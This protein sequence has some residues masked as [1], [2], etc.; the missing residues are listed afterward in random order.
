MGRRPHYLADAG[1][2]RTPQLVVSFDTETSS[3]RRGQDEVLRLRCWD[4]IV[5]D[6]AGGAGFRQQTVH[7][8]GESA[9]GL[10]NVLQAAADIEGE[11][12]AFAHNL[13]FDLA[14]TSL[15]MVL[16][17][18][19]WDTD[20]VNLG[21]ESC[22]FVM[23]RDRQKLVITDSWSWLRASLATAAK[24]VGM[25]SGRL[26]GE[27]AGLAAW[28]RRCRHDVEIL[29]RLLAELLD[30]WDQHGLGA[31]GVTGSACGW[32]ALRAMIPPRSVLVG[33]DPPRTG[34]ER[35]ALYSGRKEVWRVGEL[36]HCWVADYDLA[37]AH[38]TIAAHL[39]LPTVPLRPERMAAIADPLRPPEHIGT[40]CEV[41]ISTSQPVAPVLI[42][43]DV[44]WPV[45][46]FR[47]VLTSV[48]L[49]AVLPLAERVECLQASWYRLGDALQQWGRWCLDLLDPA[50][51]DV[52][53]VVRRVAK[54]WG[55]SVPGRFALRVSE[56]IAER[57]ATHL[58]WSLEQGTDK[59]T[60]AA[61]E[62][63]SYGGTERTYR[64][65]QDGGDVFPAVLAFVEG[66][67]RAAMA[68]TLAS[69]PPERLL[70]VNTDGWWEL[71]QDGRE[72]VYEWEAP[73]PFRVVRRAHER[74][75]TLLGPNHVVAPGDRRLSGVPKDAEEAGGD[76]F[77]WQ[78]WPGLRWQLQHS[79]P[80]EYVRPRRGLVLRDHYC[81][82]WVLATGETV[83]AQTVV[84]PDGVTVLLPW[85]ETLGRYQGDR[86]AGV[87]VPAL[88]GLVDVAAAGSGVPRPAGRLPLGRRLRASS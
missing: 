75:I 63:V 45:G 43:G 18:R 13:G 57:P 5:R 30:W 24:D 12:W 28:H 62:I 25:R 59:D 81:R 60:G 82:R 80:G 38:L 17:E 61:L 87:Q 11:A 53:A 2:T 86:L 65:D 8:A 39:P 78:D 67:L 22:V 6:R 79:R 21:D 29:D 72:T 50:R 1:A 64:K 69:R 7:R 58:G 42:D 76:G 73:A 9:A 48:E 34:F 19:G 56:L 4:A 27:R 84:T 44:W 20:F 35:R 31:F 85:S 3:E 52:P 26:P 66:H 74:G 10:A 49:A 46:T 36:R 68:E 88:E 40:I 83:P 51:D 71:C 33:S 70:Q 77:T 15:P 16:A 54:G 55:R 37:A 14:V 47:T 23:V 41:E 32:R